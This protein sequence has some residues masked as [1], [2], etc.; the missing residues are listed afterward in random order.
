[1][2]TGAFRD[3]AHLRPG[4]PR[5]GERPLPRRTAPSPRRSPA[6]PGAVGVCPEPGGHGATG[7]Q[8]AR[9]AMLAPAPPARD[10]GQ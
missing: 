6:L 10:G 3:G 7:A 1:M 4:V 5:L 8:P 9:A 2:S